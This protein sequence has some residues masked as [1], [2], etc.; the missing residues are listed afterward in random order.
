[1]IIAL[2]SKVEPEERSVYGKYTDLSLLAILRETMDFPLLFWY[3]L[4]QVHKLILATY[5]DI[6]GLTIGARDDHKG[7]IDQLLAINLLPNRPLFQV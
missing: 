1:M 7:S 5:V 6:I 3:E 2:V 4:I